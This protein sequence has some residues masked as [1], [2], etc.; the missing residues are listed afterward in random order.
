MRKRLTKTRHL[1]P[2]SFRQLHI[3]ESNSVVRNVGNIMNLFLRIRYFV[4]RDYYTARLRKKPLNFDTWG[5]SSKS[6]E[7]SNSVQRFNYAVQFAF[8]K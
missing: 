3:L 4:A 6:D 8:W 5:I 2:E 1:F 7:Q